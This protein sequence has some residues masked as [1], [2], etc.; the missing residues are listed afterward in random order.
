MK[1]V[2]YYVADDGKQFEDRYD[3]EHYEITQKVLKHKNDF[4]VFNCYRE[5]IP[6][7]ETGC[8][9]NPVYYIKIKSPNAVGV[10]GEW[11]EFYSQENPFEYYDNPEEC[12]GIWHYEDEYWHDGWYNVTKRLAEMQKIVADIGE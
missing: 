10:L 3:C 12:V 8:D 9:P 7:T 5:P 11:F 4:E 6:L 1:I 2:H